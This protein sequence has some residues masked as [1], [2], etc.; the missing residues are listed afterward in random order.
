MNDAT[1]TLV[2]SIYAVDVDDAVVLETDDGARIVGR[3]SRV[4]R[5]EAGIR[6]EVCPFDGDAP[7]YRVR[8]QR[9]PTGWQD[10]VV[11]A[12]HLHG[13]WRECGS[14]SSLQAEGVDGAATGGDPGG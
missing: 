12:R 7:Q 2:R 3:P 4:D 5:D 13:D 9:T 11:E 1:R 14:L 10:P 6:I 8:A